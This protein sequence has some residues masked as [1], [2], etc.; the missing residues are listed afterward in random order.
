MSNQV[1]ASEK[2]KF[3][4][5]FGLARWGIQSNVQVN[6]ASS[7]FIFWNSAFGNSPEET[8]VKLLENDR[9]FEV[10]K[11]GFYHIRY[12]G[13]YKAPE[14]SAEDKGV[15][16]RHY[17]EIIRPSVGLSAYCERRGI[18]IAPGTGTGASLIFTE[19]AVVCLE[20]GSIIRVVFDN[21]NTGAVGTDA[22]QISSNRTEIE[23]LKIA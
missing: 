15:R 1:W 13:A 5:Y 17:V 10:L 14:S 16:F 7:T 4:T 19:S 11:E 23:I 8:D 21:E 20:V 9:E 2:S 6:P 12:T 22:I 3:G 18:E